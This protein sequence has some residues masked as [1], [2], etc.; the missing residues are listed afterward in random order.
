MEDHVRKHAQPAYADLNTALAT[1]IFIDLLFFPRLLFAFGIPVS[2]LIIIGSIVFLNSSRSL[3]FNHLGLLPFLALLT[4]MST[5]VT[6]GM[7]TFKNVDPVESFKRVLQLSTLLFYSFYRI[8]INKIQSA[9]VFVLRGFYVWVFCLMLL[10]YS[11]PILYKRILTQIYPESLDNLEWN[12]ATF[13]Y[14]YFYTDPNSAAYLICFTLAAYAFLERQLLWGLL[15]GT[16]AT[17]TVIGTQSR[18][19]YVTLLIIFMFVVLRKEVSR[20]KKLLTILMFILSVL[21]IAS[22]YKYE[23]Q[24]AYKIYK[25]R[26]SSEDELGGGRAGKYIYFLQN[27]NVLPFGTGYN[28]LRDGFE[29]RPHS[30]LIRLNLS[31]GAF[32]LPVLLYFVLPRRKLQLPLFLVFLVPF[33]IN[34]VI[35]DY[36]LL[37]LYLLLFGLLGQLDNTKLGIY[38]TKWIQTGKPTGS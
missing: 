23:V 17:L 2:L 37:P 31:Y 27:L 11:N 21:A 28:L 19:A 9:L 18:G 33:L 13:R 20:V 24:Q 35:D 32:A 3:T 15:C 26:I 34:T 29:F 1:V 10:S 22:Y 6:L 7:L 25:L 38:K 14:S 30:D 36:R 12:L 16:L 5:S 8:Y 4:L